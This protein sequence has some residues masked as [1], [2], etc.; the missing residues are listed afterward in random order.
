MRRFFII[1]VLFTICVMFEAQTAKHSL[2][3]YV[4]KAFQGSPLLS[5]ESNQT[6]IL[7]SEKRYLHNVYTHAQT[8]LT[9]NYLF[10]PI[11]ERTSGTTSFKWNAQSAED[12]YAYD[13]GVLAVR[14]EEAHEH[15]VVGVDVFGL[16]RDSARPG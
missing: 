16:D 5:D 8:L 6:E 12:Y 13:L 15:E 10:V 4:E 7:N 3:F 1:F 11:I 9:G 14:I 2:V